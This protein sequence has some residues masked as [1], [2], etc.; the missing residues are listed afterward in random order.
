MN[1]TPDIRSVQTL[2][3]ELGHGL[4]HQLSK[5]QNHLLFDTPLVTAETASVFGEILLNELL[6]EE[7][8]S[9]R[10][11]LSILCSQIEGI[12]AT[13]FRQTVLTRFEQA[14]HGARESGKVQAEMLCDLWWA[15]NKKLYGDAVRMVESYRWGWAY[16][17]HFIHTPFYCYAY[18]YGQLLVLSLY[19]EYARKGGAFVSGYLDLLSSGGS[20]SP[21]ALVGKSVGLDL[22][23][24]SFWRRSLGLL[25]KNLRIIENLV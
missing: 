2:V 13:V 8:K 11:K 9:P 12:I 5:K 10:E 14:A 15:E 25:E 16:I 6:I 7:S 20:D 18:S 3:H 17:P 24:P 21:A 22:N 1:Y 23:D 4:H 19:D